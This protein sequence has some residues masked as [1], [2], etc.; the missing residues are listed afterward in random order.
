MIVGGP[1]RREVGL[2]PESVSVL[3]ALPPVVARSGASV[4]PV[5]GIIPDDFVP[6]PN[7]AEV[8]YCFDEPLARFLAAEGHTAQDMPMRSGRTLRM[9]SFACARGTTVWGLTAHVLIQ[10]AK[11]ALG[12]AP[13]FSEG[14]PLDME[15]ATRGELLA[16]LDP[17]TGRISAPTRGG[18]GDGGDGGGVTN[19]RPRL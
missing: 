16:R 19:A 2:P 11:L 1:A 10:V 7:A 3:C 5:I 8:A 14:W 4:R 6:V 15:D 18:G 12:R 13:E 17:A 9:H